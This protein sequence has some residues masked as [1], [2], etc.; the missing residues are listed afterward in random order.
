[1]QRGQ[2]QVDST[3]GEHRAADGAVGDDARGGD[4]PVGGEHG[5]SVGVNGTSQ[6]VADAVWIPRPREALERPELGA[7]PFVGR[8]QGGLYL[9]L[10]VSLGVRRQEV[11]ESHMDE[12]AAAT[13]DV[14]RA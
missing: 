8:R 10:D 1:M 5:P 7:Q 13:A 3:L 12:T 2:E 6:D 4:G 14:R 11:R 9:G